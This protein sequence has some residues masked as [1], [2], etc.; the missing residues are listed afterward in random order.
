M[1]AALVVLLTTLLL[2]AGTLTATLLATALLTTMLA[3]LLVLL[4]ALVLVL[5]S[6]CQSPLYV[7]CELPQQRTTSRLGDAFRALAELQQK[8]CFANGKARQ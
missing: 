8:F 3:A 7:E 2:L 6:H 4:A 5:L 1:L